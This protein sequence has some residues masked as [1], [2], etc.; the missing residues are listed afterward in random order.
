MGEITEGEVGTGMNVIGIVEGKEIIVVEA[1]AVVLV[2]ITMEVVV[3]TGWM[4]E[5]VGAGH[6]KGMPASYIVL[7]F[8]LYLF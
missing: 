8:L 2:L 6:L 3:E 5:E 1:G 4:S 7:F